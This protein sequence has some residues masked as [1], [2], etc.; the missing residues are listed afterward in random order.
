MNGGI[1]FWGL[2]QIVFIT[3]KLCNVIAWS[4]WL[5]LLPIWG[6]F[7]VFFAILIFIA[8]MLGI[9]AIFR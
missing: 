6:V 1:S 9:V 4:W 5:V 2:L 7:G 8:V 3:L